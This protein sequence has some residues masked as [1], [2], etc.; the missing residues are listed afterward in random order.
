MAPSALSRLDFGMAS[1]AINA[2]MKCVATS[3]DLAT[4]PTEGLRAPLGGEKVDQLKGDRK[5]AAAP[6][7]A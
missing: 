5:L 1:L 7:A 6:E 3:H 4:R 2:K